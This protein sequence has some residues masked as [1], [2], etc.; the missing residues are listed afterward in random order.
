MPGPDGI[1]ADALKALNG[2]R[3]VLM[4]FYNHCWATN[5]V[6]HDWRNSR[7]VGIFKKGAADD[8]ANYRPISL[9]QKGYKI[10]ARLLAKIMPRGARPTHPIFA[11][12]LQ[13]KQEHG[14]ADLHYS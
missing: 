10:Y 5:E 3:E 7:V 13:A 4:A 9:L 8:P 1:Q 14:R 6:P 12:R 11:V 2:G